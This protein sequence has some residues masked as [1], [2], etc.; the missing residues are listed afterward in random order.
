V[1]IG[2]VRNHSQ[3]GNVI[4]ASGGLAAAASASVTTRQTGTVTTTIGAGTVVTLTDALA[5]SAQNT[6]TLNG[7]VQTV[8]GGLLAGSGAELDNEFNSATLV[9]VGA[10][11]IITAGA[12]T[13]D[14]GSSF[15]KPD[16]AGGTN[17]INGQTGGAFTLA[18]AVSE[19]RIGLDTKVSIGAN[20]RLTVEG[21]ETDPG[22]FALRAQNEILAT[23]KVTFKTPIALLS[24][25][26]A[27]STIKTTKDEATV[28]TG[29]GARLTSVGDIVMSARGRGD[30][31]TKTNVETLG[32]VA[33]VAEASTLT[34]L[35]PMNT[36][37]IGP[38]TIIRTEGG[39]R[40]SA[41]TDTE[42]NRDRYLLRSITDS[43]AGTAIPIDIVSGMSRIYQTN[44][45]DIQ[46]TALV[47][48]AG[49]IRM[50]AEDK[51]LSDNDSKAKAVNWATG[52]SAAINR[53][54]GGAALLTGDI[55]A[56]IDKQ[57]G[58]V[59][60]DG[61]VRTGTNR[62]RELTLGY[63]DPLDG[64]KPAGWDFQTGVIAIS[65]SDNPSKQ[66]RK[67]KHHTIRSQQRQFEIVL[68]IRTRPPGRRNGQSRPRKLHQQRGRDF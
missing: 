49:V 39:L 65:Q 37:T 4:A 45:I 59:Q 29:N 48:A 58:I 17:N 64:N 66:Q 62:H 38:N 53:L 56:N 2:A 32:G 68:R 1:S 15:R 63:L 11:A 41:G 57:I 22:E 3:F 46:A 52:A 5:G 6:S 50:N 10:S 24:G 31:R 9:Q 42:F 35:Q 20:A 40:F 47:E 61:T 14:A 13:L 12:I 28:I 43:F 25:T 36:V 60:I 51:G 7:A 54:T 18:G 16:L 67:G 8:S 27:S 23:D 34:D 30:V 21:D 44:K 55:D 33:S 19:T 26:G